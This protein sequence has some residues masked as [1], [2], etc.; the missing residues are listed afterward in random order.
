MTEAANFIDAALQYEE[1]PYV[2]PSPQDDGLTRYGTSVGAIRGSVR[3]ALNR[4]KGMSHDDVL[5]LCSELWAAPVYE[6][7]AAAVVLLQTRVGE[8]R[9]NDLTR[10]EGYLRTAGADALVMQLVSDVLVPMFSGMDA[11]SATK[12]TQV[13]A[14]WSAEPE[15][16]LRE[17]AVA[18]RLA[19]S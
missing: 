5:A 18:V 10:I 14:R 2:Y 15:P 7:R 16:A 4:Y 1:S 19:R 3:D 11:A 8:L 6:R 12:A 17:A 9:A 13:I